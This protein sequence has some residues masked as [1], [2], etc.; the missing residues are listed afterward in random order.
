MGRKSPFVLPFL[1]KRSESGGYVYYRS[2][3]TDVRP[4]ISGEVLCPWSGETRVL[5][6]NA[7]IKVSFNT[8]D[9][10]TARQR[11]NEIH[12]QVELVVGAATRRQ[13]ADRRNR[14]CKSIQRVSGLTDQQIKILAAQGE[15]RILAEHDARLL[16]PEKRQQYFMERYFYFKGPDETVSPQELLN[17]EYWHYH[18]DAE[19]AKSL[20]RGADLETLNKPIIVSTKHGLVEDQSPIEPGEKL[21]QIPDEITA[22]LE[23][24]GIDLSPD[25]PDRR[26]I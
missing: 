4:A 18:R 25:H 11:W 14:S 9:F 5:G 16:N 8:I 6:G 24:N 2:V 1:L 19:F 26:K 22:I 7:A 23:R 10:A 21:F 12:A 20:Y 3:A 15:H 13:R 17:A